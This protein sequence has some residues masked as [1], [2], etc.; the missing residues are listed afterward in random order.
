MQRRAREHSDP[1]SSSES[2]ESEKDAKKND[3]RWRHGGKNESGARGEPA[4]KKRLV[5]GDEAREEK[6]L[7]KAQLRASLAESEHRIQQLEDDVQAKEELVRKLRA[8]AAPRFRDFGY[9]Q[10]TR[11]ACVMFCFEQTCSAALR[12]GRN[13]NDRV[14]FFDL[15]AEIVEVIVRRLVVAKA[16]VRFDHLETLER[17]AALPTGELP[18][19]DTG[20]I[21]T[22]SLV[23]GRFLDGRQFLVAGMDDGKGYFVDMWDLGSRRRVGPVATG[24]AS[25]VECLVSYSDSGITCLA[26]G[27]S[28]GL[29]FLWDVANRTQLAELSENGHNVPGIRIVDLAFVELVV[30]TGAAGQPCLASASSNFRLRDC[31]QLWDLRDHTMLG[32]LPDSKP[33]EELCVFTNTVGTEFLASAGQAAEIMIWDLTTHK[34]VAT[35]HGHTGIVRSM[36][37]FTNADGVPMLVSGSD[38]R[39]FRVW[40]LVSRSVMLIVPGIEKPSSTMVCVAG[41]GGRVLIG[42]CSHLLGPI[43]GFVDLSSGFQVSGPIVRNMLALSNNLSRTPVLVA[44]ANTVNT[45][46]GG[47]VGCIQLWMSRL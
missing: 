37:V 1:G 31:I 22:S 39:T 19:G 12:I 34:T 35:L 7:S 3:S 15:P 10:Q 47:T 43:G 23:D 44:K 46:T 5:G 14:Q 45:E 4:R 25:S 26:I 24:F 9:V 38:D 2:E 42:F 28:G 17:E 16:L 30:F 33:A 13:E 36:A 11:A 32:P 8:A 27:C 18:T 41:K 6:Q 21:M 20:F 40:D 29:I